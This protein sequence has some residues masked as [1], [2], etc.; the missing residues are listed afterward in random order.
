M[1]EI[2][3]LTLGPIQTNC[4][5]ICCEETYQ[6]AVVDPAWD[7]RSIV[8]TAENDGYEITHILLTHT[9]F[10]HVGGLSE[11]K[12][13]TGAP[14][15]VHP[16]AI[17]MLNDT[18]MSAA[19]FGVRVPPPPQPD[20]MLKDGQVIHVGNLELQ[21]LDTPGHAP[22]HVSFYLHKYR[23]LLDGDVLFQNGIGRTDLPGG[24]YEVL[25]DSIKGKLLTLPEETRVFSG[26]GSPTT[27]AEELQS[28]PFIQDLVH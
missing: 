8:A 10:D 17:D 12:N 9:H 6:A 15:Y 5:L 11:V 3:Q 22:G 24:D 25:M 2:R 16:D 20:E 21:V 28:N 7:G 13:I 4:Y 23:V 27:I 26:H 18:T 19:F 14:I 1:I